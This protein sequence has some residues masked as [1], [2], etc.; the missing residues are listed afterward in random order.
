M[1]QIRL[2]A[3][4]LA[5]ML[6]L[7]GCG[8]V[9]EPSRPAP[10][11]TPVPQPKPGPIVPAELSQADAEATCLVQ[12]SHKFGVPLKNAVVKSAKPVDAG[13]LVTLDVG[14]VARNCIIARDGFVRSLR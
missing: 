14:G 1:S 2:K 11:P 10:G 3:L 8:S 7:A 9:M 12:A 5:L 6:G 4:P 13:Y